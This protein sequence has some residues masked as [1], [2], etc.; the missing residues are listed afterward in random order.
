M[1]AITDLSDI[2]NK[3]TTSGS[4]E[5]LFFYKDARV[6]AAAATATVAGRITSLWQYNGSPNGGGEAPTSVEIPTRTTA[7]SLLQNPQS[8]SSQKWMLGLTAGALNAGTL[9]I[10]DRLLHQGDLNATLTTSQSVGGTITRNT[11]GKGNQ[12]FLEIYT[13]IGNTGTTV[14]VEYTNQDGVGGRLT[15]LTVI[16]GAGYREAQRLIRCPLQSGDTG[17]RSIENVKLTGTTAIA[18]AFGVTL[19]NVLAVVPLGVTGAGGVRDLIAGLPGPIEIEPN[20]C[21]SF[22]WLAN[23]ATAPQIYGSVHFID[24]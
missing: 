6:G 2:I 13:L 3:A 16:G 15:P 21:L 9:T 24:K 1:A 11:G 22:Y 17:V 4:H 10:Y 8:G 19:A 12:I 20:A 18:G 7:G 14:T 5:N 23:V